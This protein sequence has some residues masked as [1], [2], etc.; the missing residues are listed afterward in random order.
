[1]TTNSAKGR[2]SFDANIGGDLI[3]FFN[4]NVSPY[5]TEVGAPAFDLVPVTK[6]KDI[7]INVARLH[8]QQEYDR[9]MEMVKV[10]QKQAA[11]IKRRLEITD[12][13]HAAKYQFQIFHGKTYWLVFDS[14][15]NCTRLCMLGPEDW[16][17]GPPSNYEYITRVKWLGDYSWIEIDQEGNYVN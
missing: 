2:T 8:A 17:T 5:P 3:S 13:V 6:Q 9:I 12:A 7:M 15:D 11:S 4:K 14:K 1:M 16:C 10:L